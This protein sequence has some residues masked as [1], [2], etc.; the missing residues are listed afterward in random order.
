MKCLVLGGAGFLGSH[1]CDGLLEEGYQVRIFEKEH[2]NK[3]NV[4]RFMDRIEWV[5]GDFINPN[6][7]QEAVN[8]VDVVFHLISTTLPKSSNENT[9][10]DISTN[11]IPTLHLLETSCKMKVKKI[12]FF[13]SGGTVYGIPCNIP[14]TEDHPTN[15]ICSYGIHKLTIE[16]YLQLYQHLYGL[17]YSIMRISN[18]YGE[19]Q[20][21][22]LSQGVV[23]VFIHKILKKDPIEIW[24]DG[25]VIRDYIHVSDVVRAAI[26]LINYSG[27]YN[28]FNIGSGVG[29]SLL[30]VIKYIEDIVEFSADISFMPARSLDVSINIL[31][32]R[33]ALSELSWVP[34]VG[35]KEGLERTIQHYL[36]LKLTD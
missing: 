4:S 34:G 36:N 11:L 3:D 2:V 21:P 22:N 23:A 28:L 8:G 20:R 9:V 19:R 32:N 26:C 24:G 12:I 18:P 27:K 6:H 35:F 5:E 14:I 13:S 7:I 33:R 31:D 10:F 29:I 16:K 15:P 30:D 25:S 17:N 1:L